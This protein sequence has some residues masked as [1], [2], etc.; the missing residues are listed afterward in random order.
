MIIV[1]T[2]YIIYAF[3]CTISSAI[4]GLGY[5]FT[6]MVVSL[7]G[8]CGV[9]ILY[10]FTLFPLEMFHSMFGLYIAY[11]ISWLA[12]LLVH[13]PCLIII[14][15]KVFAKIKKARETSSLT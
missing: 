5:S 14:S 11:P 13:I 2:T 7:L 1:E 15:R 9:R 6:P 3:V 10:I 4:R 8:I 12:A